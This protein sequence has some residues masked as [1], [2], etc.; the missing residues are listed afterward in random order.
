[1]KKE[2]KRQIVQDVKDR[3]KGVDVRESHR[4]RK[5][6]YYSR[7]QETAD[8]LATNPSPREIMLKIHW[9]KDEKSYGYAWKS[10]KSQEALEFVCKERNWK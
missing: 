7:W 3:I 8:W 1:M 6:S 10:V 2:E 9:S 5:M 4:I